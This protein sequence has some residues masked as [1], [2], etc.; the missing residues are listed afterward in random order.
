MSYQIPSQQDV[1]NLLRGFKPAELQ[2]IGDQSG[3][4]LPTIM[5][6]RQGITR[7]PG[8]ETV[9]S[10]LGTPFLTRAMRSKARAT[11]KAVAHG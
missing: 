7:N 6:I 4:P 10:I 11:Q 5:K 3:V 2:A 9:R 1:R 8:L